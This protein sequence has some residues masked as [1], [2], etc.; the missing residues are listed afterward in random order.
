MGS[1]ESLGDPGIHPERAAAVMEMEGDWLGFGILLAD[2]EGHAISIGPAFCRIAGLR[3]EDI[4][5]STLPEI[6]ARISICTPDVQHRTV[7]MQGTDGG[8]NYTAFIVQ[9]AGGDRQLDAQIR[10]LAFHDPLTD[11]PNRRF[12]RQYMDGILQKSRGTGRQSAILFLDLDRFKSINDTL[13]HA[14]GDQLLKDASERIRS[15]LRRG[16]R[17]ARVGGDE[18]ICVI[19]EMN[20]EHE[21]V[22]TAGRLIEQLSTPFLVFGHELYIT[23]SIGISMFPYHGDDIE[24]LIANADTAMYRAK[25]EGRNLFRMYAYEMNAMSFEQMLLEQSLRK[26]I[27]EDE[28]LLY[29]QP[30]VELSSGAVIGLEAL[31]RWQHSEFG[32]VPP[33]EFIPIAEETGLIVPLGNW[34]LKQAC[35][36]CRKWQEEGRPPVKVSV[37]VSARQF[38]HPEFVA[39]VADNVARTG[40]R[41]EL[42]ELEITESMFIQDAAATIA[43]LNELK[44]MGVRIAVD[45]FGTGYSSLNYLRQFPL[46]VLKIDRAFIRDIAH[47]AHDQAITD[48]MIRLAHDLGLHV[49][50]EGVETAEQL[51]RVKQPR[52]DAVQGYLF[53]KPLPAE[54][55]GMWL[56]AEGRRLGH[57]LM[58]PAHGSAILRQV[59]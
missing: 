41:P 15:C 32:L 59:R 38:Q 30:Q 56:A 37:N 13:G 31:V 1:P 36:Q 20:D 34:V 11:L 40:M 7:Q 24:T 2:R 6:I 8:E 21:A 18:F 5:N 42:L 4:E 10:H 33:S 52:C 26:A 28:L 49:V 48:A 12:L 25:Q 19:P 58:I 35:I 53:S 55:I 29:Y 14:A 46:D 47:N 22:E 27:A 45:D 43:K 3:L 44:R 39:D 23:T 9:E 17:V 16:D 50:A 51:A 57:G 54:E